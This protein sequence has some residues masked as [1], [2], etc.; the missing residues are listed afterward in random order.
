MMDKFGI[1]FLYYITKPRKLFNSV[2]FLGTGTF[3][4]ASTFSCIL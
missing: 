3:G 4:I 2:T 1:N